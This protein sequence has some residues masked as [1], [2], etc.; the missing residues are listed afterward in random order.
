MGRRSAESRMMEKAEVSCAD[1]VRTLDDYIE[2][3]LSEP[4]MTKLSAHVAGCE[5]CQR[6]EGTYRWTIALAGELR[7]EPAPVEVKNR[8]RQSLNE[9]L[10][11]NIAQLA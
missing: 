4:A 9:K 8:L 5:K 11:L 3:A 10:G 7:D 1:L 6:M 2:G